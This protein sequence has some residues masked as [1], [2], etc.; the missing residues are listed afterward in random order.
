MTST[1]LEQP[2]PQDR[3][4]TRPKQRDWAKWGFGGYFTLFLVFLYGPMIVM[5]ILTLQGYYGGV[6]FP[7]R[8]PLSLNWWRALVESTVA[9]GSRNM[10]AWC[11]MG[12]RAACSVN[13]E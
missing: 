4:I 10:R 6:T 9:E 3:V 8:G 12:R 7:F 5:A 13:I 1:T 11:S 2:R